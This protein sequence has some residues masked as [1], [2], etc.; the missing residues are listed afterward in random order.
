RRRQLA[1]GAEHSACDF[2]E[3]RRVL[4]RRVLR[5][6][7]LKG[8]GRFG[9]FEPGLAW[10]QL[11]TL[12]ERSSAPGREGPCRLSRVLGWHGWIDDGWR[13]ARQGPPNQVLRFR[14]RHRSARPH[15][16]LEAQEPGELLACGFQRG[17][18]P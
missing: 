14:P 13:S 5:S 10:D 9:G 18:L 15:L 3:E 8:R 6:Q 17:R 16:L 7:P 4:E 1:G 12:L 2:S 11:A